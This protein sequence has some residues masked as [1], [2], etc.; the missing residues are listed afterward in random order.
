MT[1]E[2]NWWSGCP[3]PRQGQPHRQRAV[4]ASSGRPLHQSDAVLRTDA[5]KAEAEEPARTALHRTDDRSP[6]RRLSGS[7]LCRCTASRRVPAQHQGDRVL[8]PR[9]A[10]AAPAIR[11][12]VLHFRQLHPCG[13][14]LVVARTECRASAR[15]QAR[16]RRRAALQPE[17]QHRHHARRAARSC[18]GAGVVQADRPGQFRAAVHARRRRPAGG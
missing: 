8:L 9:R 7:R 10:V 15:C 3:R 18:A 5:G 17:L 11:A 2:P 16:G 6:V 13:V 14:I 1:S 4:C 12:T